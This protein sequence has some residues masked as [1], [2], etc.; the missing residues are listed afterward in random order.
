M[1]ADAAGS[2][3][4]GVER[5]AAH[6]RCVD[7]VD[8]DDAL[9]APLAGESFRAAREDADDDRVDADEGRREAGARDRDER[10][11]ERVASAF[12]SIVLPVPGAPR[13]GVPFPAFPRRARPRRTARSRRPRLTSSFASICPRTSASFTPHSASGSKAW[14]WERFISS[15]GPN[16]MTK[17]KTRKMGSI[18]V[19]AGSGRA[20]PCPEE[21]ERQHDHGD[22]DRRLH[23]EPPEPDAPPRDDVLLELRA[24]E[25]EQAR[26]RDQPMEDEVDETA[27]AD[28]EEE[29]RRGSTTSTTS[30]RSGSA[31]RRPRGP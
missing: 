8:E 13:K 29:A 4:A 20:W 14:I 9:A 11:V 1:A 18:T 28:D 6:P 25:P 17:L 5:L 3:E 10:R 30:P 7:L 12:A 31:R 22:P 24:L 2:P 19:A 15:N 26:A 27:E 23:P 16:R 21:V